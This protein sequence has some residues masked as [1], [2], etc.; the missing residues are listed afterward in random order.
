MSICTRSLNCSDST[1]EL[2]RKSFPFFL[3]P[4]SLSQFR[5]LSVLLALSYSQDPIGLQNT[6]KSVKPLSYY[7]S[8]DSFEFQTHIVNI[9][10]VLFFLSLIVH[11]PSR[12]H[13][14]RFFFFSLC[15]L[16][17]H[18]FF[19]EKEVAS[20]AVSKNS[21]FLSSPT[22]FSCLIYN[23]YTI[24]LF[25]YLFRNR[26]GCP[27]GISLDIMADGITNSSMTMNKVH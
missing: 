14:C 4:F 24:H 2:F 15:I 1:L 27:P 7:L 22:L 19:W 10:D 12:I 18:H 5:P 6:S 21:Y 20:P 25:W 17:S 11:T 3:S 9:L 23:I 13:L 16:N 26:H 8:L